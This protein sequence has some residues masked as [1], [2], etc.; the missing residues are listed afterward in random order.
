[1]LKAASTL[2]EEVLGDGLDIMIVRE[3]TGGMYFGDK[4][5]A[6]I[7]GG[8][9]AWDLEVYTSQEV[10]NVAIKAFEIART[11]DK[12]LTSIDK[13]NVLES[14]RLWRSVLHEVAEDYPDVELKH[15]YADNAAMQ[16]V[17]N[18]RQFDVI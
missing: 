4:G 12:R 17:R 3:L 6:G 5:R 10:E 16:L 1:Q 15:M 18:P 14:S 11:R 9:R 13:A 7:A 8:E 2:K